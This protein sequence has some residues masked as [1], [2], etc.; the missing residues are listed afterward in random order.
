MSENTLCIPFA[1][2]A[3]RQ[4]HNIFVQFDDNIQTARQLCNAVFAKFF[5]E[6]VVVN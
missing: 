6:T 3:R 2:D 1:G 4:L 5:D